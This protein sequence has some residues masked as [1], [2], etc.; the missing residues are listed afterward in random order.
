M[1]T[2]P[3]GISADPAGEMCGDEGRGQYRM[4]ALQGSI[5]AP[6]RQDAF[7]P[8]GRWKSV[9]SKTANGR[10]LMFFGVTLYTSASVSLGIKYLKTHYKI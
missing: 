4:E 10:I 7:H 1:L 9:Y 8:M 5:V 2:K 3:G 6:E